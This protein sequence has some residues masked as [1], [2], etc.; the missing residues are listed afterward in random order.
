MFYG[1]VLEEK[2][3]D[4][5]NFNNVGPAL[6]AD[7]EETY[8]WQHLHPMVFNN[9][10]STLLGN[11]IVY[12]FNNNMVDELQPI[13]H[14][15]LYLSNFWDQV[16]NYFDTIFVRVASSVSAS[17]IAVILFGV[18]FNYY[19]SNIYKSAADFHVIRF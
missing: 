17:H 4:D 2:V 9:W 1:A 3:V 10:L 19:L 13:T 15:I 6:A 14:L 8:E 11:A 12:Y 18:T 16:L 5:A 7:E